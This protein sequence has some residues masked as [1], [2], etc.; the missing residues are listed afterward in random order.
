MKPLLARKI[1]LAAVWL[2]VG[3][4]LGEAAESLTPPAPATPRING[5]SVFGV[6]PGAPFLYTIPATGARPLVFSAGGLPGGLQVDPVTGQITGS[7]DAPGDYAVTLTAENALGR[8]DRSW[9]IRVGEQIAL[10]PPMGWNSWNCWAE[11]VDQEKVLRSARAMI[12]SG[13]AEH[14]W[15]YINIDDTWQGSRG[16]PARALQAD[17]VKFP[18]M[19]A[20]CDQ[21]HRLGLKA[22]I[23]S[24]PWLTSYA[25]RAGGSANGPDGRWT[26]PTPEQARNEGKLVNTG[27][28][29]WVLGATS[30]ARQDA[31]QW[32]AWGFDYL[33][34][35]WNP[36]QAPEVAAMAEALRASGR[37]LVYSLSNAAPL[38]GAP[39]W[40]PLA[41]SWRTTGDIRDTWQSMSANG[42]SQDPWAGF[43]RPGHWNDPDMLVVGYVGWGPRL[44]PT[45]L[46]PD[47]QYTHISLWCLLSAPLLIGCDLERLAPF[48]LGLL[49]NDEVLAVDQDALGRPAH[50]IGDSEI[51]T[52]YA[53]PLED[54]AWAVGLFNRGDAPAEVAVRW[55]DLGLPGARSV[56][57]LWRQRELGTFPQGY[58]SLVPAHGVTL[59]RV[60]PP[61]R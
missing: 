15:T 24:T 7:I 5:A 23:Y 16:G 14:G 12:A 50:R 39:G 42:F 28:P 34:Y 45:R 25:R 40:V 61:P 60:A 49:T 57:D 2:A 6:R 11:S 51:R 55:A 1:G 21:I 17:P 18:D 56:R 58:S 54:G 33:K 52:V 3:L 26:P 22:G 37:D 59:I 44:H 30:F 46:T 53:K 48:T 27:Y 4:T 47:E 29:P 31:R 43:A 19:A 41:N 38:A 13:L 9:H 36:I 8:N 10:T 32:A 35:D 20:L